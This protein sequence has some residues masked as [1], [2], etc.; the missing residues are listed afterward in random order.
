MEI[1]KRGK[2]REE[3]KRKGRRGGLDREREGGL[4]GRVGIFD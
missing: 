3:M 2:G 1:V 4:L